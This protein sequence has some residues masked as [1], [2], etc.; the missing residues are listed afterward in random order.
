M[1]SVL[2]VCTANR[3]RSPIAS[4]FFAKAVVRHGDDGEIRVSSAGTWTVAGQP[5]T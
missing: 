3:F 1:A 4:I 5:A 2:F